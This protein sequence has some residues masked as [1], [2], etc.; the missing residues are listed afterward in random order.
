MKKER[1]KS[2]CSWVLRPISLGDKPALDLTPI[3]VRNSQTL[4]AFVAA[5]HEVVGR[6]GANRRHINRD[7]APVFVV[8]DDTRASQMLRRPVRTGILYPWVVVKAAI[9]PARAREYTS[10]VN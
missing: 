7:G 4:S 8:T 3:R 10:C 1:G 9:N 6:S 2:F 5:F